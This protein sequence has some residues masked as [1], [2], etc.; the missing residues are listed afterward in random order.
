MSYTFDIANKIIQ[1][2]TID[3]L[4]MMDLYSRWK[5]EVASTLAGAE[6]AMRVIKEPLAGSVFIGPYYFIMNNWQIRPLDTTHSLIVVGTVVQ[7]ATSSLTPFKVDDLTNNV[8]IVRTVATEVQVVETQGA[9][10]EQDKD[11]IVDKVWDEPL[12]GA[13]HNVATSAGRRLRQASAWLSVEG[14][15]V[16]TPTT[17][18]ISSDI[19]TGV[20]DFYNDHTFVFVSG[21]QQGQARIIVDYISSTKTFVFDEPLTGAPSAGDEFAVLANHVHPLNQIIDGVLDADL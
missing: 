10:T 17:T 6:Q 7:D 11:D 15:V 5:D 13:T 2:T 4:D 9:L 19:S 1:R 16:G 14:S 12:T 8:Q 21:S 18:S 20:D 3:E